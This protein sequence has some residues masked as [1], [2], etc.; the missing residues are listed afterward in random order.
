MSRSTLILMR[1]ATATPESPTGQDF[2]RPLTGRG[3][4]DAVH[5][6]RWLHQRFPGITRLLASPAE[7]T[8]QTAAAV[9]EA[10]PADTGPEVRRD[11]ALYLADAE[12]LLARTAEQGTPTLLLIGHN[13]GLEDFVWHL[14]GGRGLPQDVDTLMPTAGAYALALPA[15]RAP[16]VA[17]CAT[18]IAHMRPHLLD[19]DPPQ[20][21]GTH[22]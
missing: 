18:L 7:R 6:G 15:R 20:G 22:D 13:P 11:P 21:A 16:L 2:A 3:R 12:V 10:W 14:L 9:C 17:G 1:H 19:S 4:E 5:M 8:H